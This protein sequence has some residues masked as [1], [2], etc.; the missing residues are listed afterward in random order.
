MDQDRVAGALAALSAFVDANNRHDE[1]G[2]RACLNES[3]LAAGGFSGPLPASIE[4]RLGEPEGEDGQGR[5]IIPIGLHDVG[6]DAG[7]PPL[8]RMM[9]VMVEERG[10]WKLDL[11]TT[12]RA[13]I[14]ELDQVMDAMARQV[15]AAM[16]GVVGAVGD[17]ISDVMGASGEEPTPEPSM[18]EDAE[19]APREEEYHDV[20]ELTLM[21]KSTFGLSE[22]AGGEKIIAACDAAGLLAQTGDRDAAAL[23]RVMDSKMWQGVCDGANRARE[24]VR[25]ASKR[26]RS[27]R[28]EPVADWSGRCLVLDG[29]D[30]VYR[31]DLRNDDGQ[32]TTKQLATIIP[33][34]LAGIGMAGVMSPPGRSILPTAERGPSPEYYR[35]VIA[36]RVMREIAWH[37]GA[38]VWLDA[39]WDMLCGGETEAAAWCLWGLNRVLGAMGLAYPEGPFDRPPRGWLRGIRYTVCYGLPTATFENGVLELQIMP[40]N[41]EKGS[42]Y[43]HQICDV[44]VRPEE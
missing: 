37:A 33:G 15:G 5:V 8:D 39:E 9:C 13:E 6:A 19:A 3:S 20:P 25:A 31:I 1:A 40:T 22:T 26:L 41:G 24:I 44:L 12:M 7:R 27:M 36:P 11:E 18:W 2:M 29:A 16:G 43:E 21:H 14:E 35:N 28:V 32:Y 4:V 30:L 34:V 42:L 23:V 17:A 10:V 38:P